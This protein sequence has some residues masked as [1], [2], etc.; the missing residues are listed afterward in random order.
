MKIDNLAEDL[1]II[2]LSHCAHDSDPEK[3]EWAQE[4][5]RILTEKLKKRLK[6][7]K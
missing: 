6:E 3:D 7:K 2:A 1:A 5:L 4:D